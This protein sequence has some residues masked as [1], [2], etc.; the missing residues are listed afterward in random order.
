MKPYCKALLLS[1]SFLFILPLAM[2]QTKADFVSTSGAKALVSEVEKGVFSF[3][4]PN[5]IT[6]DQVDE[7]ASYYTMYF[8]VNYDE[9]N[10]VAKVTMVTNDSKS[11]HIII[12]FFVS[13]N[14]RKVKVDGNE[15]SIEEFHL[16]HLK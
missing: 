11:R 14:L 7:S 16:K 12:R 9:E 6:V 2:A 4:L 1:L 13:L 5:H 8:T 3:Q 15:L 10:H